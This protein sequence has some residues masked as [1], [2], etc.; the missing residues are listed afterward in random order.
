MKKLFTVWWFEFRSIVCSVRWIVLTVV[1]FVLVQCYL[2]DTQ[3]FA[4]EYGLKGFPAALIF[5]F[6]DYTF[7]GLG[8]LLLI[9]TT[10]V[11]PVT[12]H[13]QQNILLHSGNR[14]W[15]TAQFFTV[16][17]VVLTWVA[18]V[19]VIICFLMKDC[20]VWSKW[21]N[22]WGTKAAELMQEM[23]FVSLSSEQSGILEGY[24]TWQALLLVVVLIWLNG[25]IFGMIIF[26]VDGVC[27]NYLGEIILSV[28]SFI[29]VILGS[30]PFM[31]K[32]AFVKK[33]SPRQWLDI[34]R[35][36]ANSGKLIHTLL[37]MGGMIL[38]LYIIGYVLVRKKVIALDG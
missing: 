16:S 6:H 1:T 26:C 25:V 5:L 21:G 23:G 35:Y 22:V 30:F 36:I 37:F 17:S 15:Y 38:I 8:M 27:K 4:A 32:Y 7:C 10:S 11:F 31:T 13:L 33:F 29:W 34:E 9:F 24:E 2:G 14:I 19:Q 3:E 20:L 18:E 12:N 28:W